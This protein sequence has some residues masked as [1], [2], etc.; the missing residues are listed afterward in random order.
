MVPA[1]LTKLFWQ[2]LKCFPS[3][4]TGLRWLHVV[5]S[6]YHR[7][8]L[9]M[10]TLLLPYPTALV[11]NQSLYIPVYS[12]N[13]QRKNKV[14]KV[15]HHCVQSS[16]QVTTC[17]QQPYSLFR[18]RF[19][20]CPSMPGLFVTKYN[21]P[22]FNPNPRSVS[23]PW[24]GCCMSETWDLRY[25]CWC[26][27]TWASTVPIVWPCPFMSNIKKE[28]GVHPRVL[29]G[30]NSSSPTPEFKTKLGN[31]MVMSLNRK[32][33]YEHITVWDKLLCK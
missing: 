18:Y 33:M 3:F 17:L 22:K 15:L 13:D 20:H 30:Y 19:S 26:L 27:A 24:G 32:L 4:T 10:Q 23:A 12:L 7:S 28:H 6:W 2:N 14:R 5:I 8:S 1:I 29:Q 16:S 11:N 9:L 31:A 25:L 21:T